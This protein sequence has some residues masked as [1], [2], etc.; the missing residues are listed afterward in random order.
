M[1][2]TVATGI[3]LTAMTGCALL[4]GVDVAAPGPVAPV[5][6][7]LA[8]VGQGGPEGYGIVFETVLRVLTESGFEIAEANRLDGSIKTLARVAPGCEQFFKPGTPA[9]YE[10]TLYTLQ[11]YQQRVFVQIHPANSGGF[12]VQVTAFK[13]LEDLPRP[14]RATA[15]AAFFWSDNN[16]ERQFEVVDPTIFENNWIPRGRDL[17]LE[18]SILER[19]KSSV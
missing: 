2:R 3:L 10:R 12:F 19:I 7:N 11:T 1:V 5:P 18:Q 4:P 16:V 13:E 6:P 8:Y 9:L 15:G 14:V 17:P